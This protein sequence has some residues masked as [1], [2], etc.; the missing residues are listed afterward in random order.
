MSD[1]LSPGNQPQ[2]AEEEKVWNIFVK[3]WD[4]WK[5]MN[6]RSAEQLALVIR[7]DKDKR[8]E[9][10]L[11]LHKQLLDSRAAFPSLHAA[12][13]L[14]VLVYAWRFAR[15]LFYAMLPFVI[16]LGV[17][18]IYLAAALRDNGGGQLIGTELEPAKVARAR[19]N[20]EAA[21]DGLALLPPIGVD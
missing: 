9:E 14:L 21:A 15:P 1:N 18:T 8:K 3:Q 12:V 11:T 4:V 19:A 5:A 16:G 17:S 13:S 2:T 7:S 20:L 6:A 10:F